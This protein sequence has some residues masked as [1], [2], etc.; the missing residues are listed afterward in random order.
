MTEEQVQKL[1]QENEQLRKEVSLLHQ[2]IHLLIK[3][4]FG[5]KSEQLD[6]AQLELLFGDLNEDDTP[7]KPEASI[8]DLTVEANARPQPTYSP[9]AHAEACTRGGRSD[10]A[11]GGTGRP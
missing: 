10:S 11:P 6:P 1:V 5:H 2:K 8:V 9:N 4:V 3:R 7:G